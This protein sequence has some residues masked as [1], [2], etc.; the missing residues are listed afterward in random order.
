V[1]GIMQASTIS[2]AIGVVFM[3]L[4]IALACQLNITCILSTLPF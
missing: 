2:G 4:V 1:A 3:Q